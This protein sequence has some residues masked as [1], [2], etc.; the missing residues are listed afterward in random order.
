MQFRRAEYTQYQISLLWNEC[1]AAVTSRQSSELD[2][3]Q[4]QGLRL[5]R[6]NVR[7]VSIAAPPSTVAPGAGQVFLQVETTGRNQL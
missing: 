1:T 6:P 4:G 5:K 7:I 2:M 3:L